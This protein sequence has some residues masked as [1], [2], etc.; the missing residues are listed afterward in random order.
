MNIIC[1]GGRT[2]GPFL[3]W[4]LPEAFLVAEFGQAERYLRRLDKVVVLEPAT[5]GYGSAVARSKS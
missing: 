5:T 1:M 2:V 4:D 3:P